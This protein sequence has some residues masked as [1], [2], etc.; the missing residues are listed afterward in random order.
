MGS[1]QDKK[2]AADIISRSI[3]NAAERDFLLNYLSRLEN[4]DELA[5]RAIRKMK[6]DF[7]TVIEMVSQINAKSLDLELIENFALNTVMGQFG[8]FKLFLMRREDHSAPKIIPVASKN[9]NV[10]AFEFSAEGE[11][12]HALVA[13]HHPFEINNPPPDMADFPELQKIIEL[14]IELCVP[15]VRTTEGE[16]DVKGLLCLGKKFNRVGYSEQDIELLSLLADMI[17][18]SL[19]NAQLYHRSIFDEMTRVFS[20]GHFDMHLSQEIERARRYRKNAEENEEESS[21][22]NISLIMFDIDNF[23]KINDTYGHQVGD[24]V[25]R[26][27]ASVVRNKVR[28]ADIVARYGG[29]EFSIILP[30]TC[31]ENALKAA[32]RLRKAIEVNEIATDGKKLKITVSL[33]VS[34][35]PDDAADMH[36]LVREADKALYT[37]KAQGKNRVVICGKITAASKQCKKKETKRR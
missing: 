20:R 28:A 19:H 7:E 6:I 17:A 16:I 31:K 12:G 35:Y 36:T 13:N 24:E 33:G 15:L 25:L 26:S 30:E 9:I 14:G 29:E 23:K 11:F 1:A 5:M 37:A 8:V 3:K 4:S 18:I 34:T 27:T 2:S 10:P 21:R 32:E 22:I